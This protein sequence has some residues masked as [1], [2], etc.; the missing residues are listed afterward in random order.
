MPL[1]RFLIGFFAFLL[2]ACGGQATATPAPS[3]PTASPTSKI[4]PVITQTITASPVIA[5][6]T[7]C[8]DWQAWPVI[9]S[10]NKTAHDLYQRGRATG[11]NS[12]AF[13]KIGDGEIS[14]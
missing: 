9:P 11:T 12:H 3:L 8:E 13:S 5:Q 7:R 2:V 6:E 10:V 14:A 1:V 4:Q